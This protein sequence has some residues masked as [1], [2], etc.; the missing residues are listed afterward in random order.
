MRRT[1][2]Q[3]SALLALAA[4]AAGS[5]HAPAAH[6]AHATRLPRPGRA[7]RAVPAMAASRDIG[8][9]RGSQTG[10]KSRLLSDELREL[11]MD[12][13]L[14]ARVENQRALTK[15]RKK[16]N[17]LVAKTDMPERE[18]VCEMEI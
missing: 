16:A 7:A 5:F 10:Q 17:A 8:R 14:W 2:A 15:L 6:V 12:D 1:S 13:E 4:L 11:G 3:L 9:P 18:K